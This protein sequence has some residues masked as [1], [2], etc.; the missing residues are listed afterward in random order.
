MGLE[1]PGYGPRNAKIMIVG[2]A[3]AKQEELLGK[4]FQGQ[5]G[6]QLDK[7]LHMVGIDRSKCYITNACLERVIATEKNK[8]AYF[9]NKGVPTPVFAYGI[10]QLYKDIVE[11]KPN[12]VVVLGNYA[13]WA[14]MQHTG[15]MKWRG[16]ILWSDLFQ[17]KIIPSIH[18]AA[19]LRGSRDDSGTKKG[20]GMWKMLT[21][22][23]HDL[24]RAKEQSLFPE[25]R[26]RPR[27]ITVNPEGHD[28]D[29]A[30]TKLMDCEDLV[31]D[32][33]TFGG[34]QLA[35]AGFSP[36]DPERAWVFECDTDQRVEYIK[37]ILQNKASRKIGH[38]ITGYDVPMLDS[39]GIHSANV[40]WDTMIA[41]HVLIPDLP[42]SIAFLTSMYT[43]MKFYKDEGKI[44]YKSKV[45]SRENMMTEMF[46][47]G[48][49]VVSSAEIALA[50]PALLR[51][52]GLMPVM[53]RRMQIFG[54][55]R[56]AAELGF[57]A[58]LSKLFVLARETQKELTVRQAE[59]D[60]LAGRPINVNSNHAGGDVKTL[61]YKERGIAPRYKEGKL[62]ADAHVLADIAARNSDPV[63]SLIIRVR[64]L[65]KLL[66][67]YYNVKVISPDARIRTVYNIAGTASGRLSS[68]IPLWG[69]GVP[70]Q[71]IPPRARQAFVADDGWEIL[72]CDQAQ[73]EA[74]I[75]A[76]LANDPIHM[77]CFRTGKDVHRV[78]AALLNGMPMENWAQIPKDSQ[79][80]QLAKTCNHE[81]NYD[82]GPFMFMLTVNEEYDPDDPLSVKLDPKT[83]KVI[84]NRYH[85]IR[86]ALKGY[87][88]T[89][90][91]EL[92]DNQMTL[93]SPLGW[94]YTFLD[95]WSDS[96]LRLA[97]SWK[98]QSTVGEATN[99]G[100]LQ[101]FGL[102]EPPTT[103]IRASGQSWQQDIQKAEVK[104][105]AQTHDSATFLVPKE[106]RAEI[107]PKIMSLLEVPLYINGYNIVI[108]IEANA[109][110]NWYKGD[111]ED[112]GKT[113][114][115]VEI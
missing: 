74:V 12:V 52:R 76:Y 86:P 101:A 50:Q 89:I 40:S 9:F 11:I 97:Y 63:P 67:N 59:L 23:V 66:S 32:M 53:K 87:W 10:G 85:E 78:T 38:N 16:S 98:P 111:M 84:W 33:E 64:Q 7:M 73:A 49:D 79:V 21:A 65:E 71:T 42:K 34:A 22:V 107:A 109:G 99:I 4:P 95:R 69:P 25:L 14:A 24:K 17:V 20:G 3:P 58:D 44:L 30:L 55:L 28:L 15:I 47:C 90:R 41:Q 91:R 92:R 108:P 5:A 57:K 18:P 37:S 48:K 96:L 46:Y 106:A 1:I 62:T 68:S 26:L 45:R 100:I 39:I 114:E 61:I 110:P 8:D 54:P 6:E 112:L 88:E 72:E 19:L 113:R 77:D 31:F 13:L 83:S 115:T 75:V 81:L 104:L 2:E 60:E 51:E 43:D 70:M 94:E 36:L 105:L 56:L 102:A 35:C 82:A 93:K 29:E 27:V 103:M 80:R